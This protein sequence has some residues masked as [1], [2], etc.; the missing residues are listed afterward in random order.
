VSL[1]ERSQK[2]SK[3]GDESGAPVCSRGATVLLNQRRASVFVR[4]PVRCGR[5]P[6]S[7]H[8]TPKPRFVAKIEPRWSAGIPIILLG[9]GCG[10][11][12]RDR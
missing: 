11:T 12:Q 10:A 2:A 4:K 6:S 8:R 9:S 7:I 3:V 1:Q 5:F